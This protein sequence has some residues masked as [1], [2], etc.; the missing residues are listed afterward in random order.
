MIDKVN[1]IGEKVKCP[2]CKNK[3]E[4][5]YAEKLYIPPKDYKNK[6]IFPNISSLEYKLV[7]NCPS[8]ETGV[9]ELDKNGNFVLDSKDFIKE[10]KR[11]K[12]KLKKETKKDLKKYKKM[13][14]V[15]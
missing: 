3:F 13:F 14:G 4:I 5:E 6:E 11:I 12:K 2:Y 10:T 15:K 7:V 8:C 9:G 1:C